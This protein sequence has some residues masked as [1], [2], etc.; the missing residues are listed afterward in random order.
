MSL[1]HEKLN[2]PGYEIIE[3]IGEGGM[4][5]VYMARQTRLDR[6]IAIKVLKYG[7]SDDIN[8]DSENR[9]RFK[10][11]AQAVARINHPNLVQIIDFGEHEGHTYIIM[12]HVPGC[13]IG[14]L[15]QLRHSINEKDGY[16]IC[17]E[18][19]NALDHCWNQH[20]M[21]HCDIKP[22]NVI[23]HTDGTIKL[24]DLGL[25]RVKGFRQ[26][27]SQEDFVMGMPNYFSPEQALDEVELDCRADIYSLGAMLYQMLTGIVPFEGDDPEAV[28]R[29]NSTHN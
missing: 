26:I 21:I 12:E 17:S 19:A 5:N 14:D 10:M 15:L 3:K 24:A 7:L 28:A 4:A 27:Q 16:A 18:L 25:A 9:D 23:V 11:E 20:R 29:N 6:I 1:H 13:T 22:D 2:I 8:E